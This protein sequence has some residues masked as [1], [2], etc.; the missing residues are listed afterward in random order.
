MQRKLLESQRGG[1][2]FE[3]NTL[4]W[5]VLQQLGFQVSGLAARVRWNVPE[6]VT[7]PIGH[8]LMQVEVDEATYIVDAGF[9]GITLT[10]P[11]LLHSNQAQLTTHERFRLQPEQGHYTLQVELHGGWRS[12]YT[13][14]LTRFIQP[15][16]SVWNW[17]T[18]TAPESIF[19][20]NLMAARP[21]ASGRHALRNNQYTYHSLD[22]TSHTQALHS[23]QALYECLTQQFQLQLPVSATLMNK[24]SMLTGPSS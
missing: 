22:G 8:M 15:D 18:C 13:F 6:N 3:H 9:G 21:D 2:C 19:I 11:L 7:T 17:F 20:A 12:L 23:A 1:Y 16:Y 5:Q 4:L 10:A 24:L 14:E